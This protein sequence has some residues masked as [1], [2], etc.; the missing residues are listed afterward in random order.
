MKRVALVGLVFAAAIYAVNTGSAAAAV[1]CAVVAKAK[2]G[3]WGEKTCTERPGPRPKEYIKVLENGKVIAPGVECA[4][5]AEANTGVYKDPNCTIPGTPTEREYIKVI[6][7][8]LGPAR[9]TCKAAKGGEYKDAL[10]TEAGGTSPKHEYEW[11]PAKEAAFTST[12]GAATLKSYSPEGAE[13]P[14]VE[15]TKS[16]GKGKAGAA[17]STSVVTFEGCTSAGEKCTGGAKAKAGDIVTFE[18]E[19]TL[20]LVK[21]GEV[22]ESLVGKG[23]GGLSSEFKC[24]A[25]EI[26]TKGSVI[27]I[28]TPVNAKASTTKTLTFTATASKQDPEQFEGG[29]KDTL[30]T[31]IDGLGGGTFPFAST[32]VTTMTVKGA[33]TELRS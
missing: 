10:C 32:E 17:T 29:P 28:E 16:K 11:R 30:E 24:G 15:C 31:E 33:S 8:F 19:G 2:T 23:P 3:N 4:V 26:Q 5:V 1:R 9:G 27:G 18:L 25:N 21:P 7:P 12:T 13:L 22:G 20:G 14:A 6:A